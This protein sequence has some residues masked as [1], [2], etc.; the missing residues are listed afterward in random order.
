MWCGAVWFEVVRCGGVQWG[1][2]WC[3]AV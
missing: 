2:M 3:G 1:A